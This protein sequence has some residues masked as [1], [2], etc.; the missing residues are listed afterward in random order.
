MIECARF[1]F[2]QF[3]VMDGLEGNGFLLPQTRMLGDD[4]VPA[5]DAHPVYI[6]LDDDCMV[7]IPHRHR[8]IVAVKADQGKLVRRRG[9]LLAGIERTLGQRMESGSIF[10]EQCL[11]RRPFA[12]QLPLKVFP[13]TLFQMSVEFVEV[14]HLGYGH[15]VVEPG[16]FH[17]TFYDALLVGPA[18]TAEVLLEQVVT[19][20]L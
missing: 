11:F 18:H 17:D 6:A 4:G 3:E 2:E 7:G 13:A 1:A 9:H 19:L 16:I 20:E 8:I 5:A 15:E 10:F 14:L 12:A